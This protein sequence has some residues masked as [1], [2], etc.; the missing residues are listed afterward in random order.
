MSSSWDRSTRSR[1]WSASSVWWVGGIIL[2]LLVLFVP[3]LRQRA[4]GM[5]ST[6]GGRIVGIIQQNRNQPNNTRELEKQKLQERIAALTVEGARLKALEEEN[7]LLRQQAHVSMQSGFDVLGAQVISRSMTPDRAM[8][9]IDR[10]QRDLVEVG[11]AVLAG[12]GYFVGKISAIGFRTATVQLMTDPDSRVAATLSGERRVLGVV[13]GRG[14]G[15]ARM[16]Y[17][18]ASQPIKKDQ[19]I[20]TS[21]TEEKIP[22]HLPLGLVNA[23]EGK[24]TDPFVSAILEPLLPLDRLTFVSVLKP[25]S[26]GTN[27]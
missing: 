24:N 11:Q 12:D 3:S 19:I 8:I 10:G 17:I 16:T 9:V 25:V 2:L 4:E 18:P 20:T 5:V 26:S 6:V 14:N 21:G 7:D 1:G 15:A 27:P 13:E 23:I 22:A